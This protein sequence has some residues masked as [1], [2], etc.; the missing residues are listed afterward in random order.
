MIILIFLVG[1]LLGLLFGL[2]FG[3]LLCIRYIRQEVAGDIGPRLR[4]IQTHL[5]AL[6]ADVG[7]AI[8]TRYAEATARLSE[9]STR[10]IKYQND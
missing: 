10:P 6:E 5:D 4:T 1:S 2:L 9:E 7:L 3:A 8:G